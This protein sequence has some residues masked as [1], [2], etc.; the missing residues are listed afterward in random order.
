ML[1]KIYDGRHISSGGRND[2]IEEYRWDYYTNYEPPSDG[3]S[4]IDPA[5]HEV[6]KYEAEAYY[7]GIGAR[8]LGPRLIYR[9]SGDGFAE[10]TG[11][12]AYARMMRIA[13][14]PD[15]HV[16]GQNGMWDRV[17]DE[18]VRL[19]NERN[20]KVTSVDF[21][22][23]KWRK[24]M[25]KWKKDVNNDDDALPHQLSENGSDRY[26][27]PTI[28][29]GVLPETLSG[30]LAHEVSQDILAYLDSLQVE[31]VDVACRES[32]CKTL[33]GRRGPALH[34]PTGF[35]CLV[36]DPLDGIIDSVSAPVGLPIAA[37]RATIEGTLGPY[38]RVD[39]KL[40]AI[41]ARH[42][43]FPLDWDNED[44]SYSG[45]FSNRRFNLPLPPK[46]LSQSLYP[47]KKFW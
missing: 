43:V 20:V 13:A 25:G 9:T 26:T 24:R 35:D 22:R 11:F 1:K 39:D 21:V 23:F 4:T 19:L 10:P 38:F 45:T 5:P 7:L 32:V 29:I 36:D 40:Y 14:V 28:W 41:T 33:H 27:N 18:V 6:P 30:A 15:S 17:R 16:F 12:E 31:H 42:N 46:V 8:R 3:L 47:R 2:S 44:Y 34:R 37:C